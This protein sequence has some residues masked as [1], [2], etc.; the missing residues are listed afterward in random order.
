[1]TDF[2]QKYYIDG[3]IFN[4]D[5]LRSLSLEKMSALGTP[6]WER[7]MW[8]FIF[9][10]LSPDD[11]V[12]VQTSGSTGEPKRV[13]LL[14]KHMINSAHA[15]L[16]FF[17]LKRKEKALLCLPVK[18]IAGKMMIVRAFVGQLDLHY[19]KPESQ[20]KI[21]SAENFGFAA[22]T[23]MQ[24]SKILEDDQGIL[25]LN[26][27]EKLIIGGGTIS[28]KLNQQLQHIKSEAWQTYGMTET[29]THIALR[30]INGSQK[31]VTYRLLPGVFI[32]KN[33]QG[34]LVVDYPALGI[35][36]LVTHDLVEID[37]DQT[38]SILGRIDNV[39][40]T[41]GVK[42]FPELLEAEI[43][44]FV[45]VPFFIA[46]IPDDL[47]GQKLVVVLE[48]P[49]YGDQ[50]IKRLNEQIDQLLAGPERPKAYLVSPGFVR[51]ENDKIQRQ[52]TLK[53]NLKE[54]IF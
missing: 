9:N 23:P 15:T 31:S 52:E 22:M 18:Y 37:P 54:I 28:E 35:E 11:S 24:V 46:G 19:L 25:K 5:E 48:D 17:N 36:K 47:L 14:K 7:E 3:K 49:D 26:S 8:A 51:T 32:S 10:W 13:S 40:N 34:C 41:G 38:F 44:K 39:V 16:D 12:E 42:V 20:P 33:R 4:T 1:M 50:D 27:I 21:G 53:Q 6:E 29:I 45:S 43:Q 30:S 2:N